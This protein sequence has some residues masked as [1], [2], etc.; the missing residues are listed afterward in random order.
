MILSVK[1]GKAGKV[2]IYID[3]EYRM[4]CDSSFWYS[5]KWHNLKDINEQE[6]TE[7]EAAVSSRRAFL[8]GANLL[9]RRLHSKKELYLKLL[10]KYPK[11][12]AQSACD[13]LEELLMLD[14]EDFALR[15]AKEL[16]ERKKYAPRRIEQEL[17]LKGI[18]SEIAQNAVAALDKEDYNRIILL[19]NTKYQ[20]NLTTEKGIKRT[21]NALLRMGYSYSD[22]KKA[23][24]EVGTETESEDYE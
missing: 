12:A 2:H 4:T 10:Q 7:L 17:K 1:A 5:E 16:Y 13:R 24:D 19:L 8:T 11:E 20:T 6:L 21:V 18:S 15:Y 3:G 23:L 14:D 9:S 22:I